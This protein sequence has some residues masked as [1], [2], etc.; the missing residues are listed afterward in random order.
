[1]A[2]LLSRLRTRARLP[3][4]AAV[5]LVLTKKPQRG[6]D[7]HRIR[8]RLRRREQKDGADRRGRLTDQVFP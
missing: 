4:P 8:P 6:P 7:G 5:A 2:G 1:M 3:A